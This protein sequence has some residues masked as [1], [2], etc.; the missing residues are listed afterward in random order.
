MKTLK[1]CPRFKVCT[2]GMGICLLS[3]HAGL[4]RGKKGGAELEFS[5]CSQCEECCEYR[6]SLPLNSYNKYIPYL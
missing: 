6:D 2:S 4:K 3:W 5:G 1:E